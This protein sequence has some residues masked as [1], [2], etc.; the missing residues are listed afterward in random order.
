MPCV[1]NQSFTRSSAKVPEFLVTCGLKAI[2]T[3]ER[4][5]PAL[6]AT[7]HGPKLIR[8]NGIPRRD[9]NPV[10]HIADGHLRLRPPWKEWLEE[11]LADHTVKLADTVHGAASADGK[12]GHV[13]GLRRI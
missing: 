11:S 5:S 2:D 4:P 7:F 12:K 1:L 13:K 8:L 3:L 6:F 9:V 10:C